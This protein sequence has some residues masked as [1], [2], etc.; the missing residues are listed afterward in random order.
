MTASV[1]AGVRA[2][3]GAWSARPAHM[4]AEGQGYASAPTVRLDVFEFA[5]KF[6]R[7]RE[8]GR[9]S[10]R[11]SRDQ[12]SALEAASKVHEIRDTSVRLEAVN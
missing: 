3:V 4:E 5:F 9:D 7:K 2:W 12:P 11:S 6:T 8:F 10:L 1:V